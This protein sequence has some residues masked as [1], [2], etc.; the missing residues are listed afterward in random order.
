[1]HMPLQHINNGDPEKQKYIHHEAPIYTEMYKH[2]LRR[3]GTVRAKYILGA[4]IVL[5]NCGV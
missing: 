2:R 3:A 1:M 4:Y 5:F